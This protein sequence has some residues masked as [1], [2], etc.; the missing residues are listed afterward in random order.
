MVSS[1][2][3]HIPDERLATIRTKVEAYDWSQLPSAGGWKS[4]VGINDLKRLVASWQGSYDW[5]KVEQRLN[6][7]PT[8]RP[9]SKASASISSTCRATGPSR[10]FFCCMAGPA[11]S[12]NSSGLWSRYDAGS[13]G[14]Q[15][16][17]PRAGSTGPPAGFSFG[18]ADMP[19]LP[20]VTPGCARRSPHCR[21]A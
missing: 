16:A 4:G 11:R 20:L 19:T 5:R 21:A 14:F 2:T 3:I 12:W 13:H 9:M 17:P 10:L 1:Y 7:R 6:E 15:S 8:S 18:P